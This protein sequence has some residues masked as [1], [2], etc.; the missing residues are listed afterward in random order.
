MGGGLAVWV[1]VWVWV[2]CVCGMDVC[3]RNGSWGA[4]DHKNPGGRE[5]VLLSDKSTT[6]ACGACEHHDQ[7][8]P[9]DLRRLRMGRG[10]E[11]QSMGG[12]H[13]GARPGTEGAAGSEG[14]TRGGGRSECKSQ[15][16]TLDLPQP[17][18]CVQ[19]RARPP[20][21]RTSRGGAD[22]S[23]SDASALPQE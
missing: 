13:A 8:A 23:A 9:W 15:E 19:K 18:A 1:W 4:L 2:W 21:A 11:R 3:L 17:A 14:C 5:T 6:Q 16:H 7:P 22:C 10:M 12:A 20:P